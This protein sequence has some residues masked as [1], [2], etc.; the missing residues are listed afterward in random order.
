MFTEAQ[1]PFPY[2]VC[3]SKRAKRL[4]IKV[5]P[6]KGVQL[7]VPPRTPKN[8][9]LFFL[10]QH[11]SWIEQNAHIWQLA[12]RELVLPDNIHLPVF[13]T[14]WQIEYETTVSRK[15]AKMI[16]IDLQRLIYFG[17]DDPELQQK[18]LQQWVK[19]KAE[20][21]L[22]ERLHF[23]SEYTGLAFNKLTLRTQTTRWGS[24]SHEKNISLNYKL[25]FFPQATIDYILVH[26]LA[27]TQYL[28]HSKRFWNLVAKFVPDYKEHIKILHG[29]EAQIPRWF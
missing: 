10:S 21:Y 23:L 29:S 25:I 26:E 8:Q 22:T 12:H 17:A 28:N 13:N 19:K 4:N 1:F 16:E 9:A 6:H 7:I 2:Q 18:K 27:H 14:T 5:T 15:R 3:V 20:R 24:C 11:I